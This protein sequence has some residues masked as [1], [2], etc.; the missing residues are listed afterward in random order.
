[1]QRYDGVS[2]HIEEKLISCHDVP[3]FSALALHWKLVDVQQR[4]DMSYP[5]EDRKSPI[6][7][8]EGG[9][10]KQLKA[11]K[12]RHAGTRKIGKHKYVIRCGTFKRR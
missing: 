9:H 10:M 5:N 7:G 6:P 8:K 12:A 1:M 3:Q 4:Y 11:A 2:A